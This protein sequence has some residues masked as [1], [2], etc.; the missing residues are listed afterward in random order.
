MNQERQI[1]KQTTPCITGRA[2]SWE[3]GDTVLLWEV[4]ISPEKRILNS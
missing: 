3:M 2:L 1:L 4:F